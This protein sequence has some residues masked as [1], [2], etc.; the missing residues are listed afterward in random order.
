MH[1]D[2]QE[3]EP[4]LVF[5]RQVDHDGPVVRDG[6]ANASQQSAGRPDVQSGSA[7]VDAFGWETWVLLE[8]LAHV[9][10]SHVP[11][12]SQQTPEESLAE[13]PSPL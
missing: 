2:L 12:I 6:A 3:L 8:H 13:R 9:I 11:D 5:F 4:V 10:Y 1:Q 7:L